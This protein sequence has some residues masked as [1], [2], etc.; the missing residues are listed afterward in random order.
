MY[1]YDF[2]ITRGATFTREIYLTD[3]YG[4]VISL[5]GKSAQA[6]IRPK[7]G[8]DTLACSF[9]CAPDASAGCITISLTSAQTEAI[10]AGTYYYDLAIISSSAVDY[11]MGG[12]FIVHERVTEVS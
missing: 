12:K 11:Y 5:S 10:T 4:T 9:T 7:P 1:K 8:S 3:S 6:Q 2:E